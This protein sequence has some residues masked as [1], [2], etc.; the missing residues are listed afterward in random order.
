MPAKRARRVSNGDHGITQAQ[1]HAH[2]VCLSKEVRS[3][4]QAKEPRS[5]P[6]PAILDT[7]I[8]IDHLV[9]V[10]PD[11]DSDSSQSPSELPHGAPPFPTILG[12]ATFCF[13]EL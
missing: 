13:I 12:V 9:A 3:F 5:G 10:V 11:G 2:P 8:T 1:F 4:S 7:R 6:V